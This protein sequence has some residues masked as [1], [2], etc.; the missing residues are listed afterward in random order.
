MATPAAFPISTVTVCV[1]SNTLLS[2]AAN[3]P[4]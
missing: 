2:A 3:I 4:V 1:A